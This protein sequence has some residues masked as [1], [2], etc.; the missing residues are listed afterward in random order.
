MIG[1]NMVTIKEISYKDERLEFF[2]NKR[3]ALQKK[4]DK[5][6]KSIKSDEPYLSERRQVL[7]DY[8]RELSFY[9]DV[10]EMLNGCA[11]SKFIVPH[12][13]EDIFSNTHYDDDLE[14]IVRHD[15]I[16]RI[17]NKYCRE[18]DL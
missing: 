15:D 10:I 3:N 13:F 16:V 4:F 5:L 11:I 6:E 8:G 2:V 18:L 7:S 17:K 1:G 14:L 9:D 12:I